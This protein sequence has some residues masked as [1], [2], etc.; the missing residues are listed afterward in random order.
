MLARA[1][2]D[3]T[4]SSPTRAK[5][6]A[7]CSSVYKCEERSMNINRVAS[8]SLVV[9]APAAITNALSAASS[10]VLSLLPSSPP[11][12]S[13]VAHTNKEMSSNASEAI[14]FR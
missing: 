8:T 12:P 9:S 1:S 6:S 13:W 3:G 4:T 2:W 7:C 11:S 14:P 10:L 5:S